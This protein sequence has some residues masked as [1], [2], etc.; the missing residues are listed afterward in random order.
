MR[1]TPDF[2]PAAYIRVIQLL[3]MGL[4]DLLNSNEL[5]EDA[6]G[7]DLNHR[8]QGYRDKVAR[9]KSVVAKH[10]DTQRRRRDLETDNRRRN[11]LR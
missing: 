11:P 2:D 9:L 4:E 6:R 7:D 10:R 1:N 3:L 5:T 8:L